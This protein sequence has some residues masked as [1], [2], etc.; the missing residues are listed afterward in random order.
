M[1]QRPSLQ[2]TL[3]S[4]LRAWEIRQALLSELDAALDSFLTSTP[5]SLSHPTDLLSSVP[6]EDQA[7]SSTTRTATSCTTESQSPL[8]VRPPNEEELQQLLSISFAGLLE[9]KNELKGLKSTLEGELEAGKLAK[10]VGRVEE[11]ESKRITLTL[12]RDQLRRLAS[13]QPELEFSQSIKEKDKARRELFG[14]I[15]EEKR[16]IQAELMDLKAAA[17]AEEEER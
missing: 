7:E 3:E 6:P 13:L 15:E 14:D 16:E 17:A 4:I 5:I 12:E 1:S 8:H 9:V 2:D 10:I 11:A